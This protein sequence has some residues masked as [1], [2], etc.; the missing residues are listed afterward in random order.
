MAEIKLRYNPEAEEVELVVDEEV[1]LTSGADV[2]ESW[3]GSYNEAHPVEP[4]VE[5]ETEEDKL[6]AQLNAANEELERT[7]A[8]LEA[9]KN[10]P[11]PEPVVAPVVENP[12]APVVD[13]APEV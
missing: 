13:I 11:V 12:P 6:T 2:F 10:K 4:V 5:E 9:E 7:R 8:E 1:T 3:V